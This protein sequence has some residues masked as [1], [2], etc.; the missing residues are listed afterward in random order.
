MK[1]CNSG[2]D[3]LNKLPNA[4]VPTIISLV[5]SERKKGPWITIIV[6]TNKRMNFQTILWYLLF[7]KRYKQINGAATKTLIL[8]ATDNPSVIADIKK[9]FSLR[10]YK[11][12]NNNNVGNMSN[13]P[14]QYEMYRTIGESQ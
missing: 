13:C 4:G 10:K 8:Q 12:S 2:I 1:F 7:N 11:D 3:N 6:P 9:D 5:P 14:C